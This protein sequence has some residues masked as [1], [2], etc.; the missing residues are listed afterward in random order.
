MLLLIE[1]RNY[2]LQ[3]H[4]KFDFFYDST[5][6]H[7]FIQLDAYVCTVEQL[8]CADC[9]LCSAIGYA[10]PVRIFQA[11]LHHHSVLS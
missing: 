5:R 11:C 7:F 9:P 8:L 4:H 6:E 2:E 10:V 1:V 3:V